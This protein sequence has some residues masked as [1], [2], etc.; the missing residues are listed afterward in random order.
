VG[1]VEGV[2]EVASVVWGFIA[3]PESGVCWDWNEALE[4]VADFYEEEP[5]EGDVET[6]ELK[7]LHSLSWGNEKFE[8]PSIKGMPSIHWFDREELDNDCFPRS[9]T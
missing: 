2:R 7:Y 5:K 8:D 6:E 9:S 4:K 3:N 1:G